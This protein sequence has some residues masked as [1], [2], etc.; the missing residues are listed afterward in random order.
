M[1]AMVRSS[2]A[3]DVGTL[4]LCF[5]TSFTSCVYIF[6]AA[7]SKFCTPMA[8]SSVSW[9]FREGGEWSA[10]TCDVV[11]PGDRCGTLDCLVYKHMNRH[12]TVIPS[13]D[14]NLIAKFLRLFF[15]SGKLNVSKR[16][17]EI[18]LHHFKIYSLELWIYLQKILL[19]FGLIGDY[20]ALQLPSPI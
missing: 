16:T 18:F 10:A 7:S 12:R 9:E 17:L 19:T 15:R 6:F 4:L 5:L 3:R 2:V 1:G 13:Q 14:S 20:G 11:E 8:Q